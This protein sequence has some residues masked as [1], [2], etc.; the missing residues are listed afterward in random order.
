MAANTVLFYH[1]PCLDGSAAAWAASQVLG[2]EGVEY[3]G[4]THDQEDFLKG[5]IADHVDDGTHVYFCDIIPPRII[6]D[7]LLDKAQKITIYDHHVSAQKQLEKIDHPKCEIVF[8]MERSGAGLT[9]DMFHPDKERPFLMNIVEHMDLYQIDA[10]GDRDK[11]FTLAAGLD[12]ISV[13]DFFKFSETFGDLCLAEDSYD[14]VY[15]WGQEYRE[16]YMERIQAVIDRIEYLPLDGVDNM[17]GHKVGFVHANIYDLGREFW[18][19]FSLSCPQDPKILMLCRPEKNGTMYVSFR[20]SKNMD[21][22]CVA[23]EIGSK[24][25]ISGGGHKNAAAVRFTAEQF[26]TLV[27]KWN[28]PKS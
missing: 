5:K 9:W 20:S 10:L 17:L 1:H 25:G 15:A 4:F 3:I 28:L 8:D 22:S 2:R 23:E 26:A 14:T 6:L 7:I 11:F 24:Y 18:H 21:V 16:G 13:E 27:E 12:T 19:Q